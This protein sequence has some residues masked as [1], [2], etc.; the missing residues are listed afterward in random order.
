M[1]VVRIGKR[2]P[3]RQWLKYKEREKP[4]KM[5]QKKIQGLE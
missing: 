1:L 2:N 5:E 3:K 4:S